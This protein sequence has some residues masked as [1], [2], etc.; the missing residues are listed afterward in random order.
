LHPEKNNTCRDAPA[1]A[2]FVVCVA[3]VNNG[4]AAIGGNSD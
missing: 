1:K 4:A 2:R 3:A